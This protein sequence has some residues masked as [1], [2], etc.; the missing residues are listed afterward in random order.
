VH[1]ERTTLFTEEQRQGYFDMA[2]LKR[3]TTPEEI[4]MTFVF[5]AKNSGMTG[6]RI[7]V[8]SGMIIV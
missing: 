7:R 3:I 8:D 1:T 4:A 2:K 6:E 5:A